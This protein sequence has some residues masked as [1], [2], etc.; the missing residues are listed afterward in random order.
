[1]ASSLSAALTIPGATANRLISS[2]AYLRTGGIRSGPYTKFCSLRRL[3]GKVYQEGGPAAQ[4]TCGHADML[5]THA[6]MQTGGIRSGPYMA[7]RS[8]EA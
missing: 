4:R 6:H 2:S 8:C 3:V 5:R 7:F 1:M